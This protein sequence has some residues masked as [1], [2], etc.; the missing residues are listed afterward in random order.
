MSRRG[1]NQGSE[2][3][4]SF[5]PEKPKRRAP[6]RKPRAS[7]EELEKH[8]RA[9]VLLDV[10]WPIVETACGPVP[11]T[12]TAWKQRNKRAALDLLAAGLDSEKVARMLTIAYNDRYYPRSW[13]LTKLQELWPNVRARLKGKGDLPEPRKLSAKDVEG[14]R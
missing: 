8:V 3:Q 13:M 7:G 14:L 2:S 10:C 12:K 5:I 1:S 6:D 11:I 4:T 9:N